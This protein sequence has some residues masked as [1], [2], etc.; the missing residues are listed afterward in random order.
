MMVD[1][2]TDMKINMV[3]MFYPLHSFVEQQMFLTR[4]IVLSEWV[5]NKAPK[6]Q[7]V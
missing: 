1:G 5:T 7:M 4:G 2:Y 3:F 6:V